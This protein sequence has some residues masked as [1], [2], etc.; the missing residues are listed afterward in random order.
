MGGGKMK[1]IK[2][3]NSYVDEA[4]S[5]V[6]EENGA[7]FAFTDEKYN[8][9]KVEGVK[10]VSI[11]SGLIC[12]IDNAKKV[13]AGVNATHAEGIKLR[14]KDYSISRIIQYELANYESQISMDYSD[15]FDVLK[16]YGVTQ[17]MM[18]IEWKIYWDYCVKKDLF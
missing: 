11:G 16:D 14:L 17:E 2:S 5:K 4:Q 15:A 3:L 13:I 18:D 12:P 9:N 1:G 6:F 8:K 10:Y 7:F